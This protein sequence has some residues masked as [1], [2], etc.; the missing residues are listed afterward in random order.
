MAK[1]KDLQDQFIED[2]EFQSEHVRIDQQFV[3]IKAPVLLRTA[4]NSTQTELDELL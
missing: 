4:T 2:S 1:L 3:L